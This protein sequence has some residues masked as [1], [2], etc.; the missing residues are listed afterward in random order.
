MRQF[1][2]EPRLWAYFPSTGPIRPDSL[3]Q[4][5]RVAYQR[6]RPVVDDVISRVASRIERQS[7]ETTIDV[8]TDLYLLADCQLLGQAV[9]HLVVNAL[10]GMPDGGELVL[11]AVE[12]PG[13]VEL[14]IADSGPGLNSSSDADWGFARSATEARITA[15]QKTAEAHGGKFLARNCPEGGAAYTLHLPSVVANRAAA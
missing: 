10:E 11:T 7:I 12:A 5:P 8:A 4:Q 2:R 3:Q 9:K 15:A 14:E 1:N 6:L 13:W